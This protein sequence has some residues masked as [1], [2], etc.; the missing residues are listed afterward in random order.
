MTA[1]DYHAWIE[2]NGKIIDRDIQSKKLKGV[3]DKISK[4]RLGHEEYEFIHKE[5]AGG[6]EAI[7]ERNKNV[8]D[9]YNK[10]LSPAYTKSCWNKIKD[11]FGQCLTRAVLIKKKNIKAKIIYGSLG[12]KCKKTGKI[13]W[14][15]GNGLDKANL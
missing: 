12:L 2:F 4:I 8:V 15:H 7:I 1:F 13:W 9:H 11:E 5:W 10:D 6:Y 3:Y 14:E